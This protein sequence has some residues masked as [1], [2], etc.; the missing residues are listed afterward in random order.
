MGKRRDSRRGLLD[1][2][3]LADT[4]DGYG[5]CCNSPRSPTN[6]NQA[7][8]HEEL[9]KRK[10]RPVNEGVSFREELDTKDYWNWE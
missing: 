6:L 8:S 4:Y 3:V 7:R 10:P 9:A 2:V 5:R 1:L